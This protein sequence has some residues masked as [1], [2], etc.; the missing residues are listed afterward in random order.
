MNKGLRDSIIGSPTSED[1][2]HPED[3]GRPEDM[4]HAVCVPS[5]LIKGI[6]H[7]VQTTTWLD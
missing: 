6:N 3:M 4:G 2:G 7:A 1:M 5:C